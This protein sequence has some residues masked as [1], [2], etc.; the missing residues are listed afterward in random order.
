MYMF[1]IHLPAICWPFHEQHRAILREQ[2]L[3][4][5]EFTSDNSS[6]VK[7]FIITNA[8]ICPCF[9]GCPLF[10]MN[11]LRGRDM[12]NLMTAYGNNDVQLTVYLHVVENFG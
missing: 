5:P 1:Y 2:L 12:E 4:V 11:I 9:E 6:R 8:I 7:S 10:Q 3:R